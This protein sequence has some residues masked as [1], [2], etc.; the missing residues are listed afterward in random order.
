MRCYF[1]YNFTAIEE[2]FLC[3]RYA[4]LSVMDLHDYA[5]EI[6]ILDI[7]K[8]NIGEYMSRH[9]YD[10]NINEVKTYFNTVLDWA[11]NIFIDVEDEMKGLEWDRLYE[12]YHNKSNNPKK[13]SEEVRKLYGDPYIKKRK[14]VF[15]HILGGSLDTKLL[16]VRV[17]DEA[18]KKYLFETESRSRK[19]GN[20]NCPLCFIGH[21]SNENKI[22]KF[23]EMDADHVTAWS[24]GGATDAKNRQMLCK[25]HNRAKG[26]K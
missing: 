6:T 3:F 13:V 20:S 24:I 9:R 21:D 5:N 10:K 11:S 2:I 7:V 22:W 4:I 15:E 16:E 1:S 23:K 18:T 14:G 25:T 17:F 26:N 12:Q 8:G 19:K